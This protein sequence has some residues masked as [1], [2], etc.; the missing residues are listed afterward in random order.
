VYP[1]WKRIPTFLFN[2]Q[3]RKLASL[4]FVASDL[5]AHFADA[6]WPVFRV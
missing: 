4:S 3:S 5:M 2:L 6:V 1:A